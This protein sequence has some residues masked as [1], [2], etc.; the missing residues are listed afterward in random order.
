MTRLTIFALLTLAVLL[1]S[2]AQAQVNVILSTESDAFPT[3]PNANLGTDNI[4]GLS[5]RPD[6]STNGRYIGI[7]VGLQ[8]G[9]PSPIGLSLIHI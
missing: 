8:I 4:D 2:V 3:N 7:E 5:L 9:D 1:P 6:I